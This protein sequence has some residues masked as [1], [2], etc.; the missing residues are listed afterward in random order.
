MIIV[1]L[2]CLNTEIILTKYFLYIPNLDD[3][4]YDSRG[5]GNANCFQYWRWENLRL[6]ESGPSLSEIETNGNYEYRFSIEPTNIQF[7]QQDSTFINLL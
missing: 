7:I 5:R 4:M 3:V 1:H 6:A 2:N